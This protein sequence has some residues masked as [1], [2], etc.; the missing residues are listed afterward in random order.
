VLA[1]LEIWNRSGRHRLVDLGCGNGSF[2]RRAIASGWEVVGVEPSD[3]GCRMAQANGIGVIQGS[4][5]DADLVARCGG[6]FPCAVSTEVVEHLYFPRLW[7]K[8][9]H[10]LLEPGGI[11]VVTT[12]YHGYWKNLA[13]ALSGRLESHFH[14]LWDHGHI[15][16]FSR[17]T[18]TI[19]LQDA[20]FDLLR[21]RRLGRIPPLAKSMLLVV[22]RRT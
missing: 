12:P 1:E 9:L 16:F 11:A 10:D 6:P 14:V 3:D 8:S 7:A 4:A 2:G 13:L 5:Y 22:R 15:K 17:R 19:L 20:G 21:F 18:L